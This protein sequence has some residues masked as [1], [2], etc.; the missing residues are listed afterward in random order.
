[1]P[2][3]KPVWRI[4]LMTAEPV[5]NNEGGREDDAVDIIVGR[6]RPTPIPARSIPPR[7]PET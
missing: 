4:M 2:R 1:M 5:A 6:A 7:R 3:A